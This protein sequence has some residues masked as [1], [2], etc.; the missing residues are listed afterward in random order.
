[1]VTRPTSFCDIVLAKEGR[2]VIATAKRDI[3]IPGFATEDGKAIRRTYDV[4]PE[5]EKI[6]NNMVSK[7]QK[8]FLT[9]PKELLD[10]HEKVTVESGNLDAMTARRPLKGK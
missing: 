9:A 3:V 2:T 5:G 6:L 10:L 1:M 7:M 8:A 4:S